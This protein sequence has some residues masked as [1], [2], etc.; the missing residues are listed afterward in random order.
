MGTG[1]ERR[2]ERQGEARPWRCLNG[3]Q[4]P[5]LLRGGPSLLR[6][7]PG[8]IP[9]ETMLT[10]PQCPRS[11]L[12]GPFGNQVGDGPKVMTGVWTLRNRNQTPCPRPM[13]SQP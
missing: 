8:A 5:G 6:A 7:N 13:D 9:A 12:R 4:G 10:S 1:W 2:P 11:R 3:G